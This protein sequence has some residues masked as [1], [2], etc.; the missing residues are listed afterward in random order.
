MA[1]KVIAIAMLVC[2]TGCYADVGSKLAVPRDAANTCVSQCQ[3]IGLELDS[4][5][6]MANNV[7]CV[8]RATLPPPAAPPMS[9]GLSP[10]PSGAS[11]A[12]GMAAIMLQQM[13]QRQ[14]RQHPS[15]QQP[16]YRPPA[17]R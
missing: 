11:A 15:S 16:A 14:E 2:A 17:S 10:P 13:Q 5:V 9:P 12:G 7:G 1:M 3:S 6:V 4:V 8:C